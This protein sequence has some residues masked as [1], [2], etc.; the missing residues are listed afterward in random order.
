MSGGDG[1][2]SLAAEIERLFALLAVRREQLTDGGPALTATQ[3]NALAAVVDAGPL[4][5]GTHADRTGASDAPATRVVDWLERL[6]LVERAAD[7]SDRRATQVRSTRDSERLLRL[8]RRQLVELLSVPLSD[9]PDEQRDRFVRLLADLNA[10]L[11]G[12][13]DEPRRARQASGA[14]KGV[15]GL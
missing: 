7:P 5:L 6:R 12:A 4:R 10:V 11:A 8:R 13:P 9:V 15:G 1:P 3:R 14:R 2:A